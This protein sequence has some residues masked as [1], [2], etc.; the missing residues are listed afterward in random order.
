MATL[1]YL[2]RT[3][4]AFASLQMNR[5]LQFDAA[6]YGLG[7]GLFFLAYSLSMIPSQ[8]MLMRVVRAMM[9]M[10]RWRQ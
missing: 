10:F 8:L 5:D 7:S 3:N 9:W 6:T 4:T 2:D 1:C